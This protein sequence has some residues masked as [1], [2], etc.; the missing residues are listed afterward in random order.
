M[1]FHSA[2]DRS[3]G[4]LFLMRAR[5]AKY[6]PRTT[7]HTAS[8]KLFGKSEWVPNRGSESGQKGSKESRSAASCGQ[9]SVLQRASA[10]FQTVSEGEF[11]EVGL[12]ISFSEV[13]HNLGPGVVGCSVTNE[14]G[15]DHGLLE[16]RTT[17]AARQRAGAEKDRPGLARAAG[18]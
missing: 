3:V 9:R 16:R 12:P 14:L 4:Y 11:S 1:W 17:A 10:I 15:G 18:R 2:S 8:E 7:F 5:V 6:P 13:R